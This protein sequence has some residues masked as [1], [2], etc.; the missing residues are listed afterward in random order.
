MNI[1][2]S[3][4]ASILVLGIASVAL[5]QDTVVTKNADGTYT[6]VEY[7]VGKEVTVNLLP[8]GTF[9]GK[10]VARVVRSADATKVVFDLNGL[11]TTS[12]S[13]YAYA[14]DPAGTAT[15]LGPLTVTNGV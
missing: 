2:K 8:A 14:V 6:V 3:L 12:T 1:L 10:G 11:P 7:P 4:F 5:A 13:Y 9:T 15:M